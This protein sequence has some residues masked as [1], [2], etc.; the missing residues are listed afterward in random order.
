M[1]AHLSLPQPEPVAT[2]VFLMLSL[3][4]AGVCQVLWL[5]TV[6]SQRFSQPVDLGLTL[7]GRR[8]FGDNKTLRGF[9]VMVPATALAMV[10]FSQA[11]GPDRGLWPMSAGAYALLGLAA[12]L[13]FMLGELPNSA[14]KRQLDI[15]PGQAPSQR[16]L[17]ALCLLLDRTDS[18]LGSLLAVSLVVP[19]SW[20]IWL[21]CLLLGPGIHAVFSFALYRLG[22]KGRAG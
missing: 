3:S 17:R 2:A 13:G 15:G 22:V 7:R 5:R 14:L 19:M 11:A 1:V 10:F 20:Q 4:A 18:I 8:L 21:G 16:W 9:V 12:G 6:V